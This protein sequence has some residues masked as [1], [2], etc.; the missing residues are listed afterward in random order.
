MILRLLDVARDRTGAAMVE[1]AIVLP[2]LAIAL[3]GILQF[4]IFFYEY[5]I[6]ENAAEVGERQFLMSRVAPTT[7]PWTDTICAIE[8][9]ASKQVTCPANIASAALGLPVNESNITMS[10]GGPVSAGGTAC[11]SDASCTSALNAAYSPDAANTAAAYTASVSVSYPCLTLLPVGWVKSNF[12]SV[13]A[14]CPK[15]CL[16]ST[17]TSKVP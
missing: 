14:S 6:V 5:V 12:C 7:G 3:L 11:T 13:T 17:Y 8:G 2:L 4:G 15:G 9:S 1:F 10:T 16:T